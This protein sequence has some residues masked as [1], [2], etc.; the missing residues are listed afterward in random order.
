MRG[1]LLSVALL[2]TM[3]LGGAGLQA[4]TKGAATRF[5]GIKL[6]DMKARTPEQTVNLVFGSE[7]LRIVDP[8]ANSPVKTFP[9][10]D[11]VVTHTISSAP[12]ASAGN[13][14]AA[15][16][17]PMSAPMYMG[18]TPRNW[19]TIGTAGEQVTLRVSA[20][21]YEEVRAAFHER[22]VVIGEGK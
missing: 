15:A 8:V 22:R 11:L 20:K 2:G 12:P 9:Y 19:L 3:V 16:T 10:A 13:P 14:S 7:T 1:G 17:Q 4:Q 5:A 21:V 6:V 18:K